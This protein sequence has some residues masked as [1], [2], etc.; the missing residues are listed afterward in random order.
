MRASACKGKSILGSVLLALRLVPSEV[1]MPDTCSNDSWKHNE[2]SWE[3]WK[4]WRVSVP[5]GCHLDSDHIALL[6]TPS[7]VLRTDPGSSPS[8]A[9]HPTVHRMAHL[10][11]DV[12]LVWAFSPALLLYRLEFFREAE[13][14]GWGHTHTHTHTHTHACMRTHTHM[15]VCAHMCT[16][17]RAHTHVHA[18][19][20]SWA[21]S[22]VGL[23]CR[24]PLVC[25]CFSIK[26]IM[27]CA[28]VGSN[29]GWVWGCTTVDLRAWIWD[30]WFRGVTVKLYTDFWLQ[31]SWQSSPLCCSRVYYVHVHRSI[32]VTHGCTG[33]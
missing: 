3:A 2:A 12:K 16:H 10:H 21:L 17:A 31:V 20:H 23:N 29:I 24:G 8:D 11:L 4:I 30:R 22:G 19:T 25:G 5:W 27:Y 28:T 26:T 1:N 33:E 9:S 6:L 7:R 18:Y 13:P 15:H 32:Y 14:I